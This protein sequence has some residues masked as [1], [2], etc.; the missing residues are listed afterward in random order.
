M[1]KE[2]ID[3]Y[4]DLESWFCC[5]SVLS[6]HNIMHGT[7]K[8]L[9]LLLAFLACILSC[10]KES[11]PPVSYD[12]DNVDWNAAL[13]YVFDSSV[14]P[15][16]LVSVSKEQWNMLLE[17][18][19]QDQNTQQFVVCDVEYRKGR[20]VT[21]I[22]DAGLRLKGNTS[23]RRPFADGQY[24]H[25]HF[26]INLHKYHDDQNHSIEGLRRLDLKWFKDDAAY[27]R[28][29]FCYDLFRRSGVWTAVNN[30]YSRLW[31][32]VGDEEEIYYGVYELM[33]HIDKDYLRAR[34]DQ[35]GSKKG[36]LWKCSSGADLADVNASMGLD[37]N[38][39]PFIYELN[40]GKE[41]DFP[42][43]K[44]RLQDF[45]R[46]LNELDGKDFDDWIADHIYGTYQS[47]YCVC[48][49]GCCRT[50]SVSGEVPSADWSETP[51]PWS[52]I[53]PLRGWGTDG[54]SEYDQP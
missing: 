24:H 45:I 29:I 35:F 28:E 27:V 43:S 47:R 21:T 1:N 26:G 36:D 12:A 20:D 51:L 22:R 53:H 18:F 30:I 17:A 15:E 41:E 13:G 42:E 8:R 32:K 2:Q 33:E 5:L 38:V 3:V 7:M 4:S 14:I 25:V 48:P 23:R 37:D 39:T 44:A 34:I 10:R 54:R 11:I 19:D 6:K 16:I 49:G 52:S 31:L 40:T 46:H 9:L 50:E